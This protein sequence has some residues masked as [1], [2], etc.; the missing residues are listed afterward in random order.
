MTIEPAFFPG[1]DFP[2]SLQQLA[3]RYST[4]IS[5]SRISQKVSIYQG[6]IAETWAI[7]V[8]VITRICRAC[9]LVPLFS[10]VSV[11]RQCLRHSWDKSNAILLFHSVDENLQ[12]AFNAAGDKAEEFLTSPEK[13]SKKY[14]RWKI[15]KS[16]YPLEYLSYMSMPDNQR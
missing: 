3:E 5:V 7:S 4:K 6:D 8:F 15:E 10:N 14:R 13:W 11:T 16:L 2:V 9:G 1:I 12:S